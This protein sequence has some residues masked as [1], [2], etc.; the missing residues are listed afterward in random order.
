MVG[1]LHLL[2]F[3]SSLAEAAGGWVLESTPS[4]RR[5]E[6]DEVSEA[7]AD[8]GY[9]ARL[10]RRYEH[11]V[12]WRYVVVVQG[13]ADREEAFQAAELSAARTG[14]G[15]TLYRVEDAEVPVSALAP[16]PVPAEVDGGVTS[17]R[18]DAAPL[19]ER[20]RRASGAREARERME[21][22]ESLVLVF[23]RILPLADADLVAEHTWVRG[24]GGEWLDTRVLGDLGRS[25]LLVSQGDQAWIEVEGAWH[26]AVASQA[27]A[28]LK[29][30]SPI[31]LL[32]VPGELLELLLR[33]GPRVAGVEP[34]GEHRSCV[35][36]EA[37][38]SGDL[39]RLSIGVHDD[40]PRAAALET[41]GAP[42][43]VR[44]DDWREGETGLLVP[45]VVELRVGGDLL[46]RVEVLRI[47]VGEPLPPLPRVP[48]DPAVGAAP[49]QP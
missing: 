44:F 49:L 8:A 24:G 26:P 46:E 2:L 13:L 19:V 17:G 39:M 37:G 38:S 5:D 20:A 4:V 48:P 45:W 22:S 29:E 21:G 41:G 16:V 15:L 40:L 12:G 23:R 34:C 14:V 25:S 30:V 3:A 32:L 10:V 33:E 31:D 47:Q 28:T 11:G 18:T 35:V 42:V 43:E 36:V 6:L 27:S 7:L 1:S 9:A